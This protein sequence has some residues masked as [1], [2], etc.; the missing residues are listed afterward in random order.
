MIPNMMGIAID[1]YEV[2]FKKTL[3]LPI[4]DR[5]IF[6]QVV[7]HLLAIVYMLIYMCLQ[8]LKTI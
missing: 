8:E 1:G 4:N 2:K 7:F 3:P 6:E 5:V